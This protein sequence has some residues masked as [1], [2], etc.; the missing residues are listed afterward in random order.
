MPNYVASCKKC[1]R[2]FEYNE[3]IADRNKIQVC[4]CGYLAKRDVQ[5][6]LACA[7][8]FNGTCKSNPR[9]SISMGVPANQVE[10]F[11]ERFPESTYSPDGRLLIKSRVDKK[12]QMAERNMVELN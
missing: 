4:E 8:N 5:A 9:W 11:R 3:R 2:V 10:Q 6:E 12:R 7:G 1:G